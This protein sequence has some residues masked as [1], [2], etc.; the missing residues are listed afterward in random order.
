[1]SGRTRWMCAPLLLVLLAAAVLAGCGGGASWGSG[2]GGTGGGGNGGGNNP[3]VNSQTVLVGTGT[4]GNFVNLVMTSVTLCVPGGGSCQTIPN[5]MVDTGSYGLRLLA[6]KVT[7]ALPAV[8]A[9]ASGQRFHQCAAFADGIT[10]GPLAQAEVKLGTAQTSALSVQLIRDT[11]TGATMPTACS[12]QGAAM[13]SAA[14]L[15]ANGILGV[16]VFLQ[17][18]GSLCANTATT[19]YFECSSAGACTPARIPL[20]QQV[21]NPVAA[22]PAHN[23]G[24]LLQLPAVP[25]LGL[26]SVAGTL[27]FGIGTAGNNQFSGSQVL[28]AAEGSQAGGFTA[29]YKGVSL[30]GSIIDSGSSALF[31]DDSALRTCPSTTAAGNLSGFYC[32]GLASSL[33]E[34]A[35]ALTLTGSD[36]RAYGVTLRIANAEFL[37]TQPGANNLWVFDNIG[38][39]AGSLAGSFDLGLPFFFGRS[40]FTAF[41]QR[42]TPNGAGPWF[43]FQPAP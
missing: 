11:G 22:L 4:E 21:A 37:F 24:V 9:N 16:G 42:S 36:N 13:N 3:T 25:S 39:P 2:G 6:S 18:C 40:V 19:M 38:A 15:G 5:V 43:G 32:P 33:S 29:V 34:Q 20:T 7:L 26:T 41:E 23:N 17:D 35:L 27:V 30:P 31:F 12:N 28:V 1:M 10:W 14:A 8:N